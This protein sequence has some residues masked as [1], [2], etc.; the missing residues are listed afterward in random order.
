MQWAIHAPNRKVPGHSVVFKNK[1][2][3]HL[4]A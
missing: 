4:V 3:V 1:A 2:V